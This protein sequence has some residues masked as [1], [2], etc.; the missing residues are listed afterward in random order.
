MKMTHWTSTF[1]LRQRG[2][3]NSS[4]RRNLMGMMMSCVFTILVL[5]VYWLV[6]E[7]RNLPGLMLMAYVATFTAFSFLRIVH[8]YAYHYRILER[9]ACIV[10]TLLVYYTILSSFSWMNVMSFD[11]WWT[12]RATRNHLKTN[13]RGILVKFGWYGLYGWGAPLLATAFVV[14]TDHLDLPGIIKPQIFVGED[15]FLEL[16]ACRVLTIANVDIGEGG[17]EK[18]NSTSYKR[19]ERELYL[20]ATNFQHTSAG[21]HQARRECSAVTCEVEHEYFVSSVIALL[22]SVNFVWFVLTAY[23]IWRVRR[24][25]T[26][27]NEEFS[28]TNKKNETR[29]LL[30]VK[31]SLLMGI[32]RIFDAIPGDYWLCYIIDGFNAC[33]GLFIFIL[34]VCK[35]KIILQLWA[36]KAAYP[37]EAASGRA[38][39]SLR[40]RAS[41]DSA[42]GTA[43]TEAPLSTVKK[44]TK[45]GSARGARPEAALMDKRLKIRSDVYM[46]TK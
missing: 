9:E 12:L 5:V 15:V 4:G 46:P 32:S 18:R 41:G 24:A 17:T 28:E 39:A 8:V 2:R 11:I 19:P 22:V 31:L 25:I 45:Y 37:P 16:K 14:A 38:A 30:Y 29:F 7:L 13:R 20:R 35:K 6:K 26:Q 3:S 43:Q 36:R 40:G 1:Q 34:F 23:N 33:S 42:K 27:Y 10:M 44:P 21:N